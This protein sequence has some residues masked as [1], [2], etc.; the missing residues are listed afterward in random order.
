MPRWSLT[1][2]LILVFI[3]TLHIY[4]DC[5][6]YTTLPIKYHFLQKV[7]LSPYKKVYHVGDTIRFGFTETA[8]MIFDTVTNSYVKADSLGYTIHA[9]LDRM[10]TFKI[11]AQDPGYFFTSNDGFTF[12][13]TPTDKEFGVTWFDTKVTACGTGPDLHYSA[14]ITPRHTGIYS[15]DFPPTVRTFNCYNSSIFPADID[16]LFNLQ[17]CNEDLLNGIRSSYVNPG[18]IDDYANPAVKKKVFYFKVE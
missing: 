1:R 15:L 17:D 11:T 8:K 9:N 3:A 12:V 7:E 14:A 2:N 13:Q 4:S 5:K 16:Y 18:N 6:T 10:D